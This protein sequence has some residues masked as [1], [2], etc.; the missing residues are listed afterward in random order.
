MPDIKEKLDAI[1]VSETF[2]VD[3]NGDYWTNTTA[4][5]TSDMK[6]ITAR[7]YEVGVIN[8][9]QHKHK[10]IRQK[11]KSPTF[12]L[13]YGGT[14]RTLMI[15]CGLSEEEAKE[16][17][18]NYH[19]L[20]KVSDDYTEARLQKAASDGYV[21]V[22]FGLRLRTP[23]L[24]ITVFGNGHTPKGAVKEGRTAGNAF[25][26]SYC[27]L[28]IRSVCAFMDKVREAGFDLDILPCLQIH[29]A[30]YFL[31]KD[32]PKFLHFLNEFF[33]KEMEWQEDPAIS[34]DVLHLESELSVFYPSWKEEFTLKNKAS[35]EE[36]KVFLNEIKSPKVSRE[37]KS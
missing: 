6:T 18:A 28:T 27:M 26:Q 16:V 5:D 12:A 20:Y 37:S 2:F 11:A 13:T 10:A 14:Y 19:K 35:L 24:G 15:N 22:C 7:E 9:I 36:T 31:I 8:S 30:G 21:T 17:E 29:D 25:G 34:S 23:K 1:P 32:D 4:T 3:K 33:I